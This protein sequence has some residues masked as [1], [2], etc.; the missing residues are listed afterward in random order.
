MLERIPESCHHLKATCPASEHHRGAGD[1]ERGG[2][3][4]IDELCRGGKWGGCWAVGLDQGRVGSGGSGKGRTIVGESGRAI[5]GE[6]GLELRLASGSLVVGGRRG[7]LF[8]CEVILGVRWG[9][10]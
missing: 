6:S 7:A 3:Q 5:V 8:C 10:E 9:I 4:T 2:L 1:E